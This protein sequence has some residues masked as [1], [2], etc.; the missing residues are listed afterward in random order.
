MQAE[1]TAGERRYPLIELALSLA[2]RLL[3]ALPGS[4]VPR[5]LEL[6]T[7]GHINTNYLVHLADGRRMVLRLCPQGEAVLRKEV[8]ILSAMA[9][10]L[11]V[12]RVHLASYEPG[13]FEHPYAVL[14]W[15]EG[16][17]L[18]AAL[19][20]HPEA[21]AEI[22]AVVAATLFQIAQ[23][24]IPAGRPP[25][26]LEHV[27]HC[28]FE[29][30]AA[31]WLGGDTA[32]RFWKLI[33]DHEDL[34]ATFLQAEDFVHGDFQGDNI[35]LQE[36]GGAWCVAAVLDWEWA[37]QGCF[38]QDLG[39]LTRFQGPAAA[40]FH[41]G[42]ET[43]FA[44]QQAALPSNW[45]MLARLWDTAAHCEKL[46]ARTHRGAVTLKSVHAIERCLR[47]YATA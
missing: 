15:I 39:S 45:M 2:E 35:L 26:F 37:H 25:E 22:G 23:Q 27:H 1:A 47:D 7:G 21:A 29:G 20:F 3:R 12:P 34:F 42:L 17:S 46:T 18:D 32:L 30:G 9:D 6:L 5:T 19:G 4:P 14:E 31:R 10:T 36:R 40:G 8:A 13:S 11:P 43:G 44:R 16:V 38:F 28:L 33:Q 24:R 41:R